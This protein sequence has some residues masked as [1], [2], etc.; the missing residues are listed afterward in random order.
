MLK[1]ETS[2]VLRKAVCATMALCCVAGAAQAANLVPRNRN[3]KI[4]YGDCSGQEGRAVEFL[5][6]EIGA[7]IQRDP[8]VYTLHVVPC[9]KAGAESETNR[10][11]FVV[12][13]RKSNA[14]LREMLSEKDVPAGG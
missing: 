9:E 12:G 2:E 11:A 10:N 4:V 3:W 1:L 13:T 8:G 6:T 5:S 14:L 7:L